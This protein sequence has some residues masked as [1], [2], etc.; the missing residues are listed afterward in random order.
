MPRRSFSSSFTRPRFLRLPFSVSSRFASSPHASCAE[1]ARAHCFRSA[2]RELRAEAAQLC[3][4]D[5]PREGSQWRVA[6]CAC[7]RCSAHSRSPCP[8]NAPSPGRRCA[9]SARPAPARARARALSAFSA[10]GRC[11][12]LGGG[13]S[14]AQ[15]QASAAAL[16]RALPSLIS[17]SVSSTR[18]PKRGHARKRCAHGDTQGRTGSG[19]AAPHLDDGLGLAN[20]GFLRLQAARQTTTSLAS[21]CVGGNFPQSTS[22]R[23]ARGLRA[24]K[25][26]TARNASFHSIASSESI[27]ATTY[28][29]P[30]RRRNAPHTRMIGAARESGSRAGA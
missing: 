19:A 25:R 15:T 2:A 11:L 4:A 3:A 8:S 30:A 5:H 12:Q 18:P 27:A 9:A 13:R 28:I 22:G 26:A 6:P 16:R 24:V 10:R 21:R 14:R 23:R 17:S 1:T 7:G 29:G 20:S